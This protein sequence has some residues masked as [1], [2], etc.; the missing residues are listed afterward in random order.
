ML[1]PLP[2]KS[3]RPM[4]V[5]RLLG[6]ASEIDARFRRVPETEHVT[7]LILTGPLYNG[8]HRLMLLFTSLLCLLLQC[9]FFVFAIRI[10]G[11]GT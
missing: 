9:A 10:I 11:T 8:Y 3:F 7:L 4:A 6:V 2:G 1:V 5:S